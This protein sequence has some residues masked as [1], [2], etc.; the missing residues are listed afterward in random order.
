MV[1]THAAVLMFSRI[2][3]H[4]EN[5]IPRREIVLT[6]P[7]IKPGTA[8]AVFARFSLIGAIVVYMIYREKHWFSFT[9]AVAFVS[10]IG[11]KHLVSANRLSTFGFVRFGCTKCCNFFRRSIRNLTITPFARLFAGFLPVY[12]SP[13]AH[14]LIELFPVSFS[15]SGGCFPVTLPLQ[16]LRRQI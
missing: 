16:F 3:V 14:T 4:A 6:K 13:I 10:T 12:S 5:L 1:R 7:L 15:L 9:A 8:S 11:F 2:A